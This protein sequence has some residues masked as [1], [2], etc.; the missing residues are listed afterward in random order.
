M[1]LLSGCAITILASVAITG[2][3]AYAAQPIGTASSS[4]SFSLNG[5]PMR[6]EGVSSWPV[7]SGDEVRSGSS[8]VT[9]RFQDGSRMTIGEQS[10]VK[11]GENGDSSDVNLT[12][13]S[14]QYNLVP[15]SSIRVSNQGKVA[16][17][18]NGSIAAGS[19]TSSPSQVNAPKADGRRA[20]PPVLSS[21]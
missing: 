3:M 13:G 12:E 19:Q 8:S 4:A 15:R 6:F 20:P 9:I 5:V 21:P 1:R 17:G 16:L 11:F 2:T 10:R 7:M 14:A 18:R